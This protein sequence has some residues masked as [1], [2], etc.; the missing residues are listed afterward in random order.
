M[1]YIEFE[2]ISSH[3]VTKYY[4]WKDQKKFREILYDIY[5]KDCEREA[6]NE[7]LIASGSVLLTEGVSQPLYNK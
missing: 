6:R 1:S 2:R 7:A 5:I 4:S 3:K